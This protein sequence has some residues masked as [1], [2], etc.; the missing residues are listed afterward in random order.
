MKFLLVLAATWLI[1]GGIKFTVNFIKNGKDAFGLIGYG[2]FPSTHTS[3]VTSMLSYTGFTYGWDNPAIAA[4]LALLWV[5][6]NDAKSLRRMVGKHASSLNKLD[7]SITHRER[8]GHTI[9]EIIGG[10]VVG[11]CV[12]AAIAYITTSLI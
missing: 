9:T 11:F 10:A 3:I 12:G 1:N 5:V 2:G 7:P 4:I 6:V 8:V